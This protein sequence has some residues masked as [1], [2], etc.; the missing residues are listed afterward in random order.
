M[1]SVLRMIEERGMFKSRG[2]KNKD[3]KEKKKG[4]DIASIFLKE[5]LTQPRG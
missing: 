3:L 5:V 2:K 4:K 1:L